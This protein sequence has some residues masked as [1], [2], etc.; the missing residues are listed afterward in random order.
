M[1]RSLP[2]KNRDLNHH[3]SFEELVLMVTHEIGHLLGNP[4]SNDYMNDLLPI[5]IAED[6][7]M[8]VGMMTGCLLEKFNGL[9]D[10]KKAR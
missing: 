7:K 6:G 4:D 3:P 2:K 8:R 5:L 1:R 10:L 9:K